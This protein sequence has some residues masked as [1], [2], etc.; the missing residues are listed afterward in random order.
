MK[1]VTSNFDINSS[2]YITVITDKGTGKRIKL[3]DFE[4]KIDAFASADKK[5]QL[6]DLGRRMAS[7]MQPEKFFEKEDA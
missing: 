4:A 2:E 6:K 3:S 1:Y 7:L 5:E